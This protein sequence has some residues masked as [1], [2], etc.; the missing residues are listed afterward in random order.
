S[1]AAI[2][3]FSAAALPDA[4]QGLAVTT[5]EY[6]AYALGA[7]DVSILMATGTPWIWGGRRRRGLRF[8]DGDTVVVEV[9]AR[10]HGY[11]G[12]LCRTVFVGQ[13]DSEKLR[14]LAAEKAA[15]N[16]MLNV[17]KP[18]ITAQEL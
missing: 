17:L 10:Y 9:F 15:H 13:P 11:Y 5:G 6:A 18:G 14:M 7:E 2:D 12:H 16:R 3:A 8:Q 4:D 1:K